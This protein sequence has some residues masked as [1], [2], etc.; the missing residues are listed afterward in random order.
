MGVP[1]G[2][3]LGTL[4]FNIH[5]NDIFMFLEETEVCNYAD[6][7][8]IYACGPKIATVIVHLEHDALKI[9]E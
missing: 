6:D 8:T 3:L 5:L 4:S 9:T 2:S 7:T 1:Q